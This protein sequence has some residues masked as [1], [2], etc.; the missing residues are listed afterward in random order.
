MARLSRPIDV[1]PGKSKALAGGRLIAIVVAA[2][3]GFCLL[4]GILVVATA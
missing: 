3:A 1:V 2:V 4:L